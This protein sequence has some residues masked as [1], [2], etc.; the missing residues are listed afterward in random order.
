MVRRDARAAD[1][2]GRFGEDELQRRG[3][4]RDRE[5]VGHGG[6]LSVMKGAAGGPRIVMIPGG[7][8]MWSPTRTSAL[9]PTVTPVLASGPITAGYGKPHTE[10]IIRQIDVLVASGMP[11]AVTTGGSTA[12]IVPLSGGPDAPG[13]RMTEQPIVTGGP[14][15][16]ALHSER[17]DAADRHR[18]SLNLRAHAAVDRGARRRL[19]AELRLRFDVDRRHRAQLDALAFER[20]VAVGFERHRARRFHRDVAVLV[21]RDRRAARDDGDGAAAVLR[22]VELH[23]RLARGRAH[24]AVRDAH[25]DLRRHLDDDLARRRVRLVVA[26][27][28]FD[29]L[30]V[31]RVQREVEDHFVRVAHRRPVAVGV[32]PADD[33]GL[34]DVA[35]VE[36][37]QHEIAFVRD[38][39]RADVAADDRHAFDQQA[40]VLEAH[41]AGVV[42]VVVGGAVRRDLF[43]HRE[44]G[45]AHAAQLVPNDLLDGGEDGRR[46]HQTAIARKP[47]SV[48]K[49]SVLCMRWRTL[50][51]WKLVLS[52]LSDSPRSAIA[53]PSLT[54]GRPTDSSRPRS[55][56]RLISSSAAAAAVFA[57]AD[58]R[59]DGR[60]SSS[61]GLA[62][63]D[64]PFEPLKSLV[65]HGHASSPLLPVGLSPHATTLPATGCERRMS[66]LK[67]CLAFSNTCT[68]WPPTNFS[69][70][71]LPSEF[72]YRSNPHSAASSRMCA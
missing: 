59:K 26:D 53:S 60:S 61:T 28:G 68:A 17:R 56:R 52:A 19:Q 11:L 58:V 13:V 46:R 54:S 23:L 66:R 40:A 21:H 39:D 49:P 43:D 10:L 1:D 36:R 63:P 35:L 69:N 65:S 20:Q 32:E 27:R 42:V 34:V 71:S 44:L 16:A 18:R 25:G 9:P 50:R 72:R 14:G 64:V 41:V 51:T 62:E 48:V 47:I 67:I 33:E 7:L 30:V 70:T 45:H 57:A 29:R 4:G 5:V 38:G 37:Q 15:I 2:A 55:V 24:R 6:A 22:L 12:M 31:G 3:D 8:G